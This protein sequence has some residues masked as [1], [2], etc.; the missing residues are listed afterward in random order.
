MRSSVRVHRLAGLGLLVL[1][2]VV[3]VGLFRLVGPPAGQLA[4]LA[5]ANA[6]AAD[7]VTVLLA[8]LTL[9]AELLGIYLIA[10]VALRLAAWL[11]GA[12]G[13]LA[14]RCSRLLT[15]P[16]VRRALDAALGGILLTQVALGPVAAYASEPAGASCPPT[17]RPA[18]AARVGPPALAVITD[19]KCRAPDDRAR[20]QP[21][22]PAPQGPTASSRPP[23]ALTPL[24]SWA[25]GSPGNEQ[26]EPKTPAPATAATHTVRR[27]DTLWGIAAANLPP[28][29]RPTDAVIGRYWRQIW[30]ANRRVVGAD[31]DLIFPGTRLKVPAYRPE[32]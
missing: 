10:V 18:A 31:P 21:A 14:G 7:P 23:S 16:M 28:E 3:E 1:P 6:P 29:L 9:A 13:R 15:V 4:V 20:R 17:G 26:A 22:A 25:S 11:P 19:D 32:R 2:V 30:Q 12:P 27:G 5:G 24:P 8:A